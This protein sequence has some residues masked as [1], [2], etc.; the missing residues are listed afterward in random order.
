MSIINLNFSKFIQSNFEIRYDVIQNIIDHG[1]RDLTI[2][3][4]MCETIWIIHWSYT[5]CIV[6]NALFLYAKENLIW[7]I[8]K[9]LIDSQKFA[10]E[11]VVHIIINPWRGFARCLLDC[12]SKI[13]HCFLFGY[14]TV[15]SLFGR[16]VCTDVQT[17]TTKF[18]LVKTHFFQNCIRCKCPVVL[19]ISL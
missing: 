7:H 14:G 19:P 3:V 11:T 15:F 9:Y 18:V 1:Y 2:V 13:E 17:M 10:C 12:A 5:S 6:L 8:K 16:V 4:S